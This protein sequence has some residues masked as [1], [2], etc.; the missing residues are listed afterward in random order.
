[1]HYFKVD[2]SQSNYDYPIIKASEKEVLG[3]VWLTKLKINE[4]N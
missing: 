1:M 2:P 4:K 3:L